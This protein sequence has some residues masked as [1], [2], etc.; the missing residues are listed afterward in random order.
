MADQR[1][2]DPE[3]ADLERRARH[4]VAGDAGQIAQM[5]REQRRREVARQ[6]RL[7]RQRAARRP[8]DVDLD[9]GLIER[10]EEAQ[11]LD[12]VHVQ[13]GQQDVDAA[14][15]AGS[16][17]PSR[18]MPVPASSTSTCRRRRATSTLEVLPP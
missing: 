4:L 10:G 11:A 3:R 16:W 17:A 14:D 18:R 13:V 1:G 7:E 9:V 5:H 6:P 15:A 2:A 8:P 12:V